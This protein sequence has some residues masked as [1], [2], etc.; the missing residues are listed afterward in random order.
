MSKPP[1]LFFKTKLILFILINLLIF[2]K[3]FAAENVGGEINKEEI[4]EKEEGEDNTSTS[5]QIST[6]ITTPIPKN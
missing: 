4:N 5:T 1:K 6:T 3:L 2:N